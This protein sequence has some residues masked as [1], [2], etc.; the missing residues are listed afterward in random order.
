MPLFL[1]TGTKVTVMTTTRNGQ[2]R[3]APWVPW[4]TVG[5]VLALIVVA[6]VF[7]FPKLEDIFASET[8]SDGVTPIQIGS[9]EQ[10]AEIIVP[11]YWLISK[12]NEEKPTIMTPDKKLTANLATTS[13]APEVAISLL[14]ADSQIVPSAVIIEPV[15]EDSSIAHV[16]V[17]EEGRR[18]LAAVTTADG[19][20]VTFVFNVAPD[21]NPANYRYSMAELLDGVVR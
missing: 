6:A 9:G 20:A 12:G 3:R 17:D 16:D 5:V 14:G 10:T 18:V 13:E 2:K 8:V 15:G 4:V 19:T 11:E 21:A 1:S 7:V